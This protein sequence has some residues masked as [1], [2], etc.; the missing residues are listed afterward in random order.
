MGGE[1]R[2]GGN[3][4]LARIGLE[5]IAA[6]T[7]LERL[8]DQDFVVMQREHQKLGLRLSRA[9]AAHELQT[10]D[11]GQQVF[12]QDDV[13]L[14]LQCLGDRL[15]AIGGFADDLEGRVGTKDS[16]YSEPNEVLIIDNKN[17]CHDTRYALNPLS[18]RCINSRA[19]SRR[20]TSRKTRKST[21]RARTSGGGGCLSA[22]TPGLDRH[23][24][25][26]IGL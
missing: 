6:H 21:G 10:G 14:G 20:W 15:F 12:D 23:P 22:G 8:L 1:S 3:Q 18:L 19:L 5:E 11:A 2:D 4:V 16:A 26:R 25:G 13:G 7:S 24:Q 17:A 9:N